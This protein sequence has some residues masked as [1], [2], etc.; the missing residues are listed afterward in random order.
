M[1]GRAA[2]ASRFIAGGVSAGSVARSRRHAAGVEHVFHVQPDVRMVAM[3][4]A[5]DR[6]RNCRA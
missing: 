6:E 3:S 2:S 5:D 4:R 1:A